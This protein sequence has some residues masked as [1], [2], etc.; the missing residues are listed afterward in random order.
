MNHAPNSRWDNI[1]A[2]VGLTVALPAIY[3]FTGSFLKYEMNLLTNFEIFVPP[4]AIMIGG[5]ILAIG[6]NLFPLFR[7]NSS[8]AR[9]IL[10]SNRIKSRPWNALIISISVLILILL[11]GY[12]LLENLTENTFT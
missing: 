10:F 5:L 7:F 8:N 4:P 6:I 9:G 12:V 1:L 2:G 11:F 3:F